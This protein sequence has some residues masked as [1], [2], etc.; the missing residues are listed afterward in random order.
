MNK[1]GIAPSDDG[2]SMG[3][4][5]DAVGVAGEDADDSLTG[6]TCVNVNTGGCAYSWNWHGIKFDMLAPWE[7]GVEYSVDGF[8]YRIA[9]NSYLQPGA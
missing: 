2:T 1:L 7:C 9:T 4:T 8:I 5:L 6:I 3:M